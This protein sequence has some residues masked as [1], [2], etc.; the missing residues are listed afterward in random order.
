MP[1]LFKECNN[2]FIK[3]KKNSLLFVRSFFIRHFVGVYLAPKNTPIHIK[4]NGSIA[5]K[6]ALCGNEA[7]K[8]VL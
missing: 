4:A 7:T 8:Q 5:L 1:L 6:K 3:H 2:T